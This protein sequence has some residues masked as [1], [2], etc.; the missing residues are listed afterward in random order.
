M[1]H[2]FFACLQPGRPPVMTP[3]VPGVASALDGQV[4]ASRRVQQEAVD[5]EGCV[6]A[7]TGIRDAYSRVVRRH[8]GGF[9]GFHDGGDV[10]PT[11]LGFDIEAP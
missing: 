11:G 4:H 8:G 2:A 3:A 1:R 6:E 5:P 10:C 9:R 7:Y